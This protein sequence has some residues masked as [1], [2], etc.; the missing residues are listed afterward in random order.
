M[1]AISDIFRFYECISLNGST[2]KHE[3]MK[4]PKY[5]KPVLLYS[6][7]IKIVLIQKIQKSKVKA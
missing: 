7:A 3:I 5:K 6:T 4:F 1:L 2:K